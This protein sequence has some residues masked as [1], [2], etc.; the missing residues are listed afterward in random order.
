[1]D[2]AGRF[3][4]GRAL[5][6]ALVLAT[7]AALLAACSPGAPPAATQAPTAA[8]KPTAQPTFAAV[9]AAAPPPAGAATLAPAPAATSG[10]APRRGGTLVYAASA[11]V[12][13]LDPTFGGGVP[14]AAVRY[15]LYNALVKYCHGCT[16]GRTGALKRSSN[17][18]LPCTSSTSSG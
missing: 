7:L 15:M 16:V 10:P 18:G 14:S 9:Q 1:M 6:I 3:R 2:K 17:A 11:D 13:S 5:S 12:L 4:R 8:A